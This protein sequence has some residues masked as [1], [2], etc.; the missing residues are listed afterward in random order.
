MSFTIIPKYGETR[1]VNVWV[2][3][4]MLE[5]IYD[6]KLIDNR[7]Y[8]NMGVNDGDA[9]VDAVTAWKIADVLDKMVE[10]MGPKDR[11]LL[12]LSIT[13]KPQKRGPI[14]TEEDVMEGYSVGR[15]WLKEFSEFSRDSGG[16]GVF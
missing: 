15:D 16:F 9:E 8:K 2:W 3:R 10:K 7:I 12:D 5:L 13:D 14:K 6:A 11:L 4:P 1:E